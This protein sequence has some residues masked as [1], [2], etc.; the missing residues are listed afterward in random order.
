MASARGSR[1]SLQEGDYPVPGATPWTEPP[2][3]A[4]VPLPHLFEA[5]GGPQILGHFGVC[6]S[7]GGLPLGVAQAVG[8][9][10]EVTPQKVVV[11]VGG[12]PHLYGG[13]CKWLGWRKTQGGGGAAIVRRE[14]PPPHSVYSR[15]WWDLTQG[16]PGG[17]RPQQELRGRLGLGLLLRPSP[18]GGQ[19]P[20]RSATLA[21]APP[22]TRVARQG[23][24]M[25]WACP[26]Q[27][28]VYTH[29]RRRQGGRRRE[30]RAT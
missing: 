18:G 10:L 25:Q 3:S 15:P 5:S 2:A 11:R 22:P 16:V 17:L 7:L 30:P 24:P 4:R 14:C 29:P 26:S 21:L 9:L 13:L 6:A 28:R 8:Q 27:G 19:V 20:P 1:A 23:T 12:A